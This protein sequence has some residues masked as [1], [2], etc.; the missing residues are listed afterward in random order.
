MTQTTAAVFVMTLVAVK[1]AT[2]VNKKRQNLPPG[3]C[4]LPLV[5]YLPF[6]GKQPP[7]TFHELRKTYGDVISISMGS[8][9]AVVINGREAIKEA[10]VTKGDDFS[11]RPAFTTAQLLNDGKN[12]GFSVFGPTWKMHRKIVSNVLYTFTNARNNPI[13]DIIRTEAH[14]VIEEFLA[15]GEK[16]FCPRDSMQLAA[17]SLVFQ[18]CYGAHQNIREDQSFVSAVN[19]GREFV[20]FTR[21]GNPVDVMPW[22]RFIVPHKV[23]TQV[24]HGLFGVQLITK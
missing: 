11:G 14:T 4:G 2:M 12:F 15:H 23:T 7:V 22:L 24:S 19:G 18:L 13:E 16:S 20:E 3:P 17:S 10:L 1:L 21:A 9:P 6:F 5:G 8:W